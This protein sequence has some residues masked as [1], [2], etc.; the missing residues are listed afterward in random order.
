MT[1]SKTVNGARTPA[2]PR[3]GVGVKSIATTAAHAPEASPA[4][5]ARPRASART[6]PAAAADA[7]KPKQKLVRDSFTIPKLEY[8]VLDALKLRAARLMRPTKKS[9]VLRAGIAALQAMSDEDFLAVVNGVPSLKTG[10]P[11]STP[12]V[13][14][15]KTAA[16]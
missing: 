13:A 3:G 11:R 2:T 6:S 1:N 9:E 12:P 8:A 4:P 15:A 7:A 5:S 16:K 10:R 14:P